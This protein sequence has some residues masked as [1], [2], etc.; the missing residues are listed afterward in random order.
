MKHLLNEFTQLHHC[1]GALIGYNLNLSDMIS[2]LFHLCNSSVQQ[3]GSKNA[4]FDS[5]QRLVYSLKRQQL[6]EHE[7]SE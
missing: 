4:N 7:V 1:A 5:L 6:S 2:N 3:C